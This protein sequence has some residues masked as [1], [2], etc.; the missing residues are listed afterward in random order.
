MSVLVQ[1]PAPEFKTDA[2]LP[3]GS[4]GSVNLSDYRGKYV[5][6]FFY[7]FDFTFVCPTE[8][9]AFSDRNADFE[10]LGVQVLGAS[11]DSKFVHL[12][13]RKD[14]EELRNL[15]F[16]MLADIK[17]ELSSALGVLDPEAGVAQP[18]PK[19]PQRCRIIL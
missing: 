8:I 12:A 1:Q 9:I 6:L 11:I 15:P 16:P 14:K 4:F 7:P 10:K 19:G 3:D 18:Q 13:W 17:R 2:V 5:L